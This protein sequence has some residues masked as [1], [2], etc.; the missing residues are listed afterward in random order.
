MRV[1]VGCAWCG[2]SISYNNLVQ[3]DIVQTHE[4]KL[5]QCG[6][7]NGLTVVTKYKTALRLDQCVSTKSFT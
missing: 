5:L 6:S 2:N 4:V 1:N 7:C 3:D